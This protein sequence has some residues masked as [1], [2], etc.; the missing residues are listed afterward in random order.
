MH[1]RFAHVRLGSENIFHHISLLCPL[2]SMQRAISWLLVQV[3]HNATVFQR[4][5]QIPVYGVPRRGHSLTEVSLVDCQFVLVGG[6]LVGLF[7]RSEGVG[8]VKTVDAAPLCL[9]IKATSASSRLCRESTPT[10][11]VF[12]LAL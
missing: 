2:V 11:R 12:T 1:A 8:I 7:C 10:L 6:L 4:E 9:S 3:I 5:G